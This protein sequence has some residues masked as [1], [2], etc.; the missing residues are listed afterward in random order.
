M[1]A[2]ADGTQTIEGGNTERGGEISV[3]RRPSN[4]LFKSSPLRQRFHAATS[5]S[6]AVSAVRSIAAG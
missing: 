6:R 2:S 5:N 3:G 1:G 4:P